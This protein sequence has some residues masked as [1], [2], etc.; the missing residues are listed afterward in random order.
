MPDQSSPS[1]LEQLKFLIAFA[2]I[3]TIGMWANLMYYT[4]FPDTLGWKYPDNTFQC[5]Q[6][7][8]FS[9]FYAMVEL[10]RIRDPYNTH[11]R[12]PQVPPKFLKS[13]YPP[14]AEVFFHVFSW[15]DVN[16]KEINT[17]GV[18]KGQDGAL[19]LYLGIP[20]IA[21]PILVLCWLKPPMPWLTAFLVLTGFNLSYPMIFSIDRGNLEL[22]VFI[23]ITLFAWLAN[24][25][26]PIWRKVAIV[27]IGAAAALKIYPLVFTFIYL[28]Q[29]RWM[30]AVGVVLTAAA[31]T[32]VSYLLLDGTLAANIAAHFEIVRDTAHK[33]STDVVWGTRYSSSLFSLI[34]LSLKSVFH[35][36][37]VALW[38]Q[39]H[40][41][42]VLWLF[43]LAVVVILA[44]RRMSFARLLLAVCCL[45]IL[46]TPES[47]DYKLLLLFP[48]TIA[49]IA[50]GGGTR[51][52]NLLFVAIMGLL[53]VAKNWVMIFA[54][55][56][57]GSIFNPF[58][59]LALLVLV[60][61]APA[62]QGVTLYGFPK[63]W[64]ITS[65]GKPIPE[66]VQ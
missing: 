18:S 45:A 19:W 66:P 35:C 52:F 42:P 60:I 39:F 61:V 23:L 48:A 16:Y 41:S 63:F 26:F 8:R 64:R 29:R 43:T 31:F 38:F 34:F 4:W 5:V 11:N 44:V 46:A 28:K 14:L 51:I 30:A 2:F 21:F 17:A 32:L 25:D 58:L 20:F 36:E 6:V 1:Q 9:D 50:E 37:K 55:V 15:F 56:S 12:Q 40:Y 3:A 7:S 49:V 27:S 65:P 53:L 47:P 22:Y 24:S 13:A 57:Y 54:E 62:Q 59:V 10:N 33:T